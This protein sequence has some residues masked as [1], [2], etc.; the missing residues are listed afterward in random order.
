MSIF[1]K[2]LIKLQ[3]KALGLH[4]KVSTQ[5]VKVDGLEEEIEF[6]TAEI[7]IY[8]EMIA[9]YKE[10][11]GGRMRSMRVKLKKRKHEKQNIK[12]RKKL[13][14]EK[15]KL[16]KMLHNLKITEMKAIQ[17]E[18]KLARKQAKENK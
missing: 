7:I 3:E 2:P 12:L 10:L 4:G 9:S 17:L 11:R 18:K 14:T 16:N 5:K 15:R 13:L 6:N 1:S 8:D